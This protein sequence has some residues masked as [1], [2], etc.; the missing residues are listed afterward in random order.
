MGEWTKA[1]EAFQKVVSLVPDNTRGWNNLAQ[2]L[3]VAGR[4]EEARTAA[5]SS[6]SVGPTSLAYSAL[7]NVDYREGR[8]VSSAEAF[9]MAVTLA[10][11]DYLLWFNLAE[12]ER[13]A[14]GLA[15]RS[16]ESYRR[17]IS[18]AEGEL[19]VNPRDST[20]LG[21]L[22][23]SFA[24]TGRKTEARKWSDEALAADPDDSQVLT[25]A[26]IVA[27]VAGD[28]PRALQLLRRAVD[29]GSKKSEIARDPEFRKLVADPAFAALFPGSPGEQTPSSKSKG[30]P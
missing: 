11:A 26:A 7:G 13:W 30:G 14:P 8:F 25:Q 16:T 4:L 9:R 3:T 24:K 15:S 6:L 28:R 5:K 27:E 10:P 2:T 21:C 1:A 19:R 17:A 18:L 12:A 29:R 20:V 22:A 23:V